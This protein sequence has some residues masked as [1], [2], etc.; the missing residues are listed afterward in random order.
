MVHGLEEIKR[1]NEEA[2]AKSIN[3]NTN[4]QWLISKETASTIWHC[5]REIEVAEELLKDINKGHFA[6]DHP[7]SIADT[8][9]RQ[10]TFQLGVP[11]SH[12]S[13]RLYAVQPEL[14][15]QM[16]KAHIES[17]KDLLQAAM[18]VARQELGL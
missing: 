13:H 8:F 3:R 6:G 5:Y 2:A 4:G 16:I 9:D 17:Q 12:S 10:A 15:E 11:T 14:A 1:V 7:K 18:V